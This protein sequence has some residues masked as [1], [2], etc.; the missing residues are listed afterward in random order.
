MKISIALATFN[1]EKY[2]REQLESFS[3]QTLKPDELVVY[4]D[5]S[6]DDTMAIIHTFAKDAPFEVRTFVSSQSLGIRENFSRAIQACQ[7]DF[8]F[9]SDQD[10]VWLEE[11]V[12]RML[13]V[14]RDDCRAHLWLCDT[15]FASADLAQIVADPK[16]NYVRKVKSNKRASHV[17]G[18]CTLITRKFA[19][20]AVPIP[21]VPLNHDDW[22]HLLAE[23]L[24]IR[25]ELPDALQLYRRHDSNFTQNIISAPVSYAPF[26]WW[27]R[28]IK[29]S[30]RKNNKQLNNQWKILKAMTTVI[31]EK[32]SLYVQLIGDTKRAESILFYL[33]E[34]I[35]AL[36]DRL[37]L[38]KMN[39]IKRMI[40]ALGMFKRG[41]YRCFHS[42][43][44]LLKDVFW[45]SFKPDKEE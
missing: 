10:D 13:Q 17:M 32:K 43:L 27:G 18:C 20:F 5:N 35:D 12:E 28:K 2:I 16:L 19:H 39:R 41:E 6:T 36:E 45:I 15:F 42:W 37:S 3:R 11:K 40:P 7:G 29:K 21:S 25:R 24:G 30:L 4:D 1:G 23:K 31:E 14:A 8:I 9:L 34:K 38:L 26:L 33:Q 44:S 22:L